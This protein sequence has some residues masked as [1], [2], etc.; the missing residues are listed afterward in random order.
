MRSAGPAAAPLLPAAPQFAGITPPGA[1]ATGGGDLEGPEAHRTIFSV[2]LFC[3]Q[4]GSDRG[5]AL[6]LSSVP[7]RESVQ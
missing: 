1:E 7:V 3:G 2:H 4:A 5:H 6:R